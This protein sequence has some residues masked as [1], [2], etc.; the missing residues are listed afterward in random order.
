MSATLDL[1][2]AI[3]S[4]DSIEIENNF[5][6]IMAAK[7]SDKLDALRTEVSKNMFNDAQEESEQLEPEVGEV[8]EE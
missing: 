3:Q 6:A 1:I 2:N 4:G 7:V 5:N 8:T